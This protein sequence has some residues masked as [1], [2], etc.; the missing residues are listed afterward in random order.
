MPLRVLHSR[1]GFLASAVPRPA[2]SIMGQ[3]AFG[4]LELKAAVLLE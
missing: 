4:S 3:G 2:T 1:R